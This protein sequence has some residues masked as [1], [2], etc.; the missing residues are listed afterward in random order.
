[1]LYWLVIGYFISGYNL[2]LRFSNRV[3]M[4]EGGV[5]DGSVLIGWHVQAN[6]CGDIYMSGVGFFIHPRHLDDS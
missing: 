4:L 5:T 3:D 1:M 6:A 2:L